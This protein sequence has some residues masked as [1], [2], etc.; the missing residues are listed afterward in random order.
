[1]N[2]CF[3]QGSS[4]FRD[5]S[6]NVH[7]FPLNSFPE[8]STTKLKPALAY[9]DEASEHRNINPDFNLGCVA[10]ALLSAE[11]SNQLFDQAGFDESRH[12]YVEML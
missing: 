8:W 3:G 7:F 2:I 1:M 4:P 9:P 6:F 5:T 12:D 11:S 10:K